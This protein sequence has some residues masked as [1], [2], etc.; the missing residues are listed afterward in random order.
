MGKPTQ[1]N[2]YLLEAAKI[3]GKSSIKGFKSKLAVIISR[4]L[5]WHGFW[6]SVIE[7]QTESIVLW[8]FLTEFSYS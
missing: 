5:H 4:C 6:R 2:V 7:R 8:L 3:A 1:A